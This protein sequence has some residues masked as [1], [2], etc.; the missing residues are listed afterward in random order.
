MNPTIIYPANDVPKASN[1]RALRILASE[2]THGYTPISEPFTDTP[3]QAELNEDRV[4]DKW[5]VFERNIGKFTQR[6]DIVQVMRAPRGLRSGGDTIEVVV[7]Q[8]YFFMTDMN[9]MAGSWLSLNT[10]P[11]MDGILAYAYSFPIWSK[12]CAERAKFPKTKQ[13]REDE[14]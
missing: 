5:A 1:G 13:A 14:Y 6:R 3:T 7:D 9:S 10:F 4:I 12:H 8:E 11:L 2:Q